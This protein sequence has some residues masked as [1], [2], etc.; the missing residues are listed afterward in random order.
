MNTCRL[1][2]LT[3][4]DSPAPLFKYGVRHYAHSS[5]GIDR[6]GMKFLDMIPKHAVPLIP[7]RVLQQRGVLDL[8]IGWDSAKLYGEIVMPKVVQR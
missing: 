5:C 3:D 6:W 4:Y 7:Y 1:C 8:V 2:K